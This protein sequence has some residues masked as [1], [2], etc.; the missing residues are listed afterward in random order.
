MRRIFIFVICCMCAFTTYAQQYKL[1][2]FLETKLPRY[3]SKEWL[4]LNNAPI[5]FKVSVVDNKLTIN[6]DERHGQAELAIGDGK[7]IGLNHGEWGGALMFKRKSSQTDTIKSGNIVDIFK[8]Q[9][10]TYF[11][12]GL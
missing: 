12:E 2:D 4:V 11:L 6:K 5:S 9:N 1:Y 10:Q 3:L 8:F 7:L